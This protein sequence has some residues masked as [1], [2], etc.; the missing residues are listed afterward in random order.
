VIQLDQSFRDVQTRAKIKFDELGEKEKIDFSDRLLHLNAL[1]GFDLKVTSRIIGSHDFFILI[2][3]ILNSLAI[4]ACF[5]SMRFL[6][7]QKL[8]DLESQNI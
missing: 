4:I 7:K 2:I 5:L 6:S 3:I 1:S 8:P